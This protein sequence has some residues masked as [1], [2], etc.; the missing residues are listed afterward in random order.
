MR[1]VIIFT[2]VSLDGFIAKEDDD[3]QWL[4]DLPNESDNHAIFMEFYHSIDT[5]LIGRITMDKMVEGG[6]IKPFS[7][8]VNY[9]FSK[10][11][12]ESSPGV[13]Y[14]DE[15]IVSFVQKLKKQP[16]KN[17][18][19][20]GGGQINKALLENKLVDE[21]H[22]QIFPIF[23]GK[24]KPLAP[25]VDQAIWLAPENADLMDNG[26]IKAVYRIQPTRWVPGDRR[27]TTPKTF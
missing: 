21:I 19:V 27:K 14:V 25:L 3:I 7:D 11:K 24:G 8:K 4:Y 5:T 17:I 9:A 13:T 12:R 10:K 22:L 20:V 6:D 18:W 16:G 1:K 2:A 23:L 26:V 15:D